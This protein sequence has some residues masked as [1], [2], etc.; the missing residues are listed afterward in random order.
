MKSSDAIEAL[1]FDLG[2]VIWRI[3][4]RPGLAYWSQCTGLPPDQFLLR[5]PVDAEFER[6]ERGEISDEEY[7]DHFRAMTGADIT[8][9]DFVTGWDSILCE[10]IP[11]VVDL[12]QEILKQIPLYAFS[13]TN[14]MHRKAWPAR[15]AA[16]LR[17]F[18]R[19]FC[20]HQ[21]GMRKPEE[22]G[23][24]HVCEEIGAH[25]SRV[26][27]FD[28]KQENVLAARKAGLRAECVTCCADIAEALRAHGIVASSHTAD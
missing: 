9:E 24:L 5:F 12:L 8:Y 27:F 11:G 20:S 22:R 21:I 2:N 10:E 4:I 19:I 6:H 7:F 26:L 17:C 13:N 14:E 18:R 1:I 3:D 28:D 25:P 15:Y 23:F 16:A